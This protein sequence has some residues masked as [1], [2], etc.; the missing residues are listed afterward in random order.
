MTWTFR[1]RIELRPGSRL[2]H[3]E[4]EWIIDD[5]E[6]GKQ[7]KVIGRRPKDIPV[8]QAL[9][10]GIEAA[11]GV[12]LLAPINEAPRLILTGT[13][14]ACE[15]DAMAAGEM[16]RGRLMR[17]FA[18]LNIGADF[19]GTDG[20]GGGATPYGL[21]MMGRG[22]KVLNDPPKL[23]A[24]E[25]D[26]E[27]PLFIVANPIVDWRIS[28]PHERLEDALTSVVATGGLDRMRQVSYSLYAGS[29]GLAPEP[30]FVMLMMAFES[31]LMPK[32]RS[33]QTQTHVRSMMEA[34]QASGLSGR[35]VQSICGSLNWLLNQSISQAGRELAGS[36][37]P[38]KYLNGEKPDKF[39]TKCYEV[40]SRLLHGKHPLPAPGELGHL[41]AP[42]ERLVA[43]LVA[44]AIPEAE[45]SRSAS[46][47]GGASRLKARIFGR[48]RVARLCNLLRRALRG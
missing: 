19:G 30:R 3:G 31:L 45:D 12:P 7:V 9:Q 26:D 2:Q 18:M 25:A 47:G 44:H 17:A 34:T 5:S 8:L 43:D 39:F 38:R 13:G 11:S 4:P 22:R 23:W 32:P 15:A 14:Y 48:R 29:F 36:L 1:N 37:G 33:A 28:S 41:A 46:Q 6:P 24:Y 40:R 27:K 20:P 42:L 16:W 10:E 35:E 21:A